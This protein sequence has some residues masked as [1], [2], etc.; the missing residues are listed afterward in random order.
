MN[1]C[2]NYICH[3]RL[4]AENFDYFDIQDRAEDA[5]EIL[6]HKFTAKLAGSQNTII[7]I[8]SGNGW[9]RIVPHDRIYFVDL[10]LKNLV[11]LKS[12]TSSPVV[13]DANYLPFKDGS[14][15]FI[16][17]SEILEHLNDPALAAREIWRVLKPGG[18]AIVST[19]YKERI[20]YSL[21]IHCNKVTPLNAH[22][23][24]FDTQGLSSMF[25]MATIQSYLFGSK[26]LVMLRI[27]TLLR[28][29]PL[30][31]WRTLDRIFIRLTDKAQHIVLVLK[32]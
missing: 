18:K 26:V 11:S 21:C 22:L 10:S 28:R 7:D 20:K 17:A 16:I 1:R 14:S 13:T 23:H 25:P 9:T 31:V 4:D 2:S 29:F 19:P 32:K 27:P 15:D 3:Y 30:W 8:G 12:D 5:Y 24:S 6:F